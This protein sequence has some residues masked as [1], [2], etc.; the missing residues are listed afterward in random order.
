MMISNFLINYH[1]LAIIII[2]KVY[3]LNYKQIFESYFCPKNFLKI[4]KEKKMIAFQKGSIKEQSRR[5]TRS[6]KKKKK[7]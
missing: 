7:K 2:A 6:V 5:V 4:E 3:I 1:Q